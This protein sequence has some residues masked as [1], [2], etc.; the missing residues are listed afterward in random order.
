MMQLRNRKRK[1]LNMHKNGI[2]KRKLGKTGSKDVSY[3]KS[4]EHYKHSSQLGSANGEFSVNRPQQRSLLG[5]NSTKMDAPMK[6]SYSKLSSGNN[7]PKLLQENV[8]ETKSETPTYVVSEPSKHQPPPD[9]K[10][11]EVHLHNRIYLKTAPIILC[12]S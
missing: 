1:P 3:N 2:M 5:F 4:G 7:T 11:I 9:N 8:V 6:L 10:Y 12:V